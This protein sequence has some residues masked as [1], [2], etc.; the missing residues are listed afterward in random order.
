M[1]RDHSQTNR[2]FT[3]AP[4][5]CMSGRPAGPLGPCHGRLARGMVAAMLPLS[6][7]RLRARSSIIVLLSA[8]VLDV[9]GCDAT[10]NTASFTAVPAS[11]ATPVTPSSNPP[12]PT[13]RPTPSASPTPEPLAAATSHIGGS[14]KKLTPLN[15]NEAIWSWLRDEAAWLLGEPGRCVSRRLPR[16]GRRWTRLGRR[17]KQSRCLGLEGRDRC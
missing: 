7:P 11:S 12:A 1:R 13:P 6:F 15:G 16:D 5:S 10:A 3:P 8:V 2:P 14:V 9:V 17:W 4:S